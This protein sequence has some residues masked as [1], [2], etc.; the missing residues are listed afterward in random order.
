MEK[1]ALKGKDEVQGGMQSAYIQLHLEVEIE[2][3]EEAIVHY[4]Y[5]NLA[6]NF[7]HFFSSYYPAGVDQSF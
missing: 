2:L 5:A 6:L 4:K 1:M 7:K 3:K